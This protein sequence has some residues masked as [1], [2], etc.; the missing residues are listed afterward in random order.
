MSSNFSSAR[1]RAWMEMS[2]GRNVSPGLSCDGAIK[3]AKEVWE[4]LLR[5]GESAQLMKF[6]EDLPDVLYALVWLLDQE[7]SGLS[8]EGFRAVQAV[9]EL[10][11]SNLTSFRDEGEGHHLA[12]RFAYLAWRSRRRLGILGELSLL[13]GRCVAHVLAQPDAKAFLGLPIGDRTEGL[14]RRFLSEPTVLLAVCQSLFWDR[15]RVPARAA[16][17]AEAVYTWLSRNAALLG[18]D[19]RSYFCGDVAFARAAALRHLGRY[20]ESE[21]WA[22]RSAAWFEQSPY[23]GPWLA[24]VE[25]LRTIALYDRHRQDEALIRIPSLLGALSRFGMTEDL[26]KCRLTQALLLKDRG[27]RNKSLELLSAMKSDPE[28]AEYPLIH[29]LTLSN[30][31]EILASMGRFE[32]GMTVLADA[33]PILERAATPWAFAN[34][35][36]TIAEL[37]RDNDNV[38]GAISA[39]QRA[40]SIYV[41]QGMDGKAAYL[42]VVLAES[43]VAKGRDREAVLELLIALRHFDR[44]AIAPDAL[45]AVALLRE[46]LRRQKADPDALRA[47]RLQLQRMREAEQ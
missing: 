24:K 16:R 15:N 6:G 4:P 25:L 17:E 30:I 43:L 14:C 1:I 8:P 32:A 41:E 42:R 5:G 21:V 47:F 40:I 29:G 45:V 34:L 46:S 26:Q 2:E 12:A 7:Q 10:I 27:E 28:V 3:L 37:L 23:P 36:A 11:E 39:Y 44:E 31:G 18:P 13:E 20:R 35:Q 19:D 9:E 38:S 33:V 22:N